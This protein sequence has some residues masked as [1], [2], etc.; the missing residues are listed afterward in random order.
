MS[1]KYITLIIL[2]S[3]SLLNTSC[4]KFL[5]K[6]SVQN[7]STP[8]TLKDLVAMLDDEYLYRRGVG[9]SQTSGDEYYL[10]YS[11]WQGLLDLKKLGYVWDPLLDDADDWTLQYTNILTTNVVL[12]RLKDIGDGSM[13]SQGIRGSALFLRSQ[14]F[15]QLAQLYATQYDPAT[16]SDE[17]GIVLRLDPDFNK[18]S[19]RASVQKTYDQIVSDLTEAI[20]LLPVTS[21]ANTRPNKAA[22]FALL[23]RVYLQMGDYGKAKDA[24]DNS[25]QLY[26]YLINYNDLTQVDTLSS[27]P[28]LQKGVL[29]KEIIFYLTEDASVSINSQTKIDST[30]YRSFDPN[31]IRRA[32]F[33]K[34][35]GDGTFKYKGS[36]AGTIAFVGIGTAEVYLI[37]AECNA[38]LGNTSAALQDL[39][40]LLEKRY[41]TGSFIP[42]TASSSN[43]ALDII[44]RERK[45]EL[46]FRGMRWADLKRLNKE[47]NRAITLKR[48]LNGQVYTLPPNDL[49]YTLLIPQNVMLLSNLRQND[50]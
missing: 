49:R 36:Y 4:K 26:S 31:D 38:R 39:N 45:K 11:Y 16:A 33:F 37:R 21:A 35:F 29:N 17:R 41:K 32:A 15:F 19:N 12:D 28:F 42:V 13:Q 6:K 22:A 5:D 1:P 24:A 10:D 48:I 40:I 25:L 14:C 8:E 20:S 50:R 9:L 3:S 46:V 7:L 23:A 2:L 27:Q 18:P 44:L 47:T 34:P 43:Q 30:L